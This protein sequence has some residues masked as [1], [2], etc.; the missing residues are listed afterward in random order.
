M[1]RG[2]KRWLAAIGLAG[3]LVLSAA[4]PAQAAAG[5]NNDF[6]CRPSAAHPNPVV[7]LHGTFS[8]YYEDLNF[9]QAD[10]ASRGYC[11]FS[12]TYGAYPQFPFVGGLKPVAES[13]LEIKNFV[14][15]VR[16][17]TGAAQV[18][19][20]GHSEGGL[21]SI[22]L[23]KMQ[24]IQSEIGKVVAIAPPTHGANASGLLT[25]AYT[26]LGK[27]TW[28]TIVK[29]IGLPI[30]ADELDGGAAI[31]ALNTGP[32]A[33]PGIDYTI[34]T[35]RY[36]ELVTPTETSFIREPGVHNTYVQDSCPFDPVG[37]IGE[38]YDL[39]VWHLV[40]NALDPANA[41]PIKVCAVGSPG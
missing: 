33:Q 30:F 14:E 10:L 26:L 2:T 15:K 22:Y 20:V 34:I 27:S 32:V 37:H 31:V 13:S 11:T 19:V 5:G 12:L 23:A 39:N 3:A 21:Q 16:T 38:A 28:D 25:L 7:L 35:S 18:D 29:T 8:T 9:L 1:A 6:A 40:R 4:V 36:D 17:A 41:A 24:G